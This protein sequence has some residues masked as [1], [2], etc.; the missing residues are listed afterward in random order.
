[1]Q[2]QSALDEVKIVLPE[3]MDVR[4][5]AAPVKSQNEEDD[6]DK[7]IKE[8]QEQNEANH[9][10]DPSKAVPLNNVQSEAQAALDIIEIKDPFAEEKKKEKKPHILHIFESNLPTSQQTGVSDDINVYQSVASPMSLRAS[11]LEGITADESTSTT[12]LIQKK[13]DIEQDKPIQPAESS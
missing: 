2:A 12:E 5:H 8:M 6:P 10:K 4:D 9:F 11:K 13:K 7:L 1:M 3:G